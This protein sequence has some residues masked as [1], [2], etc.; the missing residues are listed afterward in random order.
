MLIQEQLRLRQ[1]TVRLFLPEEEVVV[2]GNPIQLEQVFLNLLTNARDAVSDTPQKDITIT[3]TLNADFV[4]IRVRDSGSG[5]PAELEK[6]IFDP[7]FTTKEVGAGTGLGLSITYSIIQEHQGNILLE[8]HDGE[9]ALFL[10]QLPRTH[11]MPERD[12]SHE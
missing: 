10:I 1:I 11:E 4:E 5:I 12:L 3:C 8:S 7:F 9:G 2:I 6:R